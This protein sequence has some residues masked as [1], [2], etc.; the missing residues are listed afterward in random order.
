MWNSC[1]SVL[2]NTFTWEKSDINKTSEECG[3]QKRVNIKN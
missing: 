1:M 3:K 2:P